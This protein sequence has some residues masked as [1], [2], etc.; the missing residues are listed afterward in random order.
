MDL[1]PSAVIDNEINQ[2]R[3]IPKTFM[4]SLSAWWHSS[5]KSGEES[6]LRMLRL[7]NVCLGLYTSFRN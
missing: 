1:P 6:E 2:A 5:E 7:V 4:T 3:A